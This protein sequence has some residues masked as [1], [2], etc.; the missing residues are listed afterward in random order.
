MVFLKKDL[1]SIGM[2]ASTGG[3][4]ALKLFSTHMLPDADIEV[5]V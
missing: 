1:L 4:E 5:T 3:L 2:G